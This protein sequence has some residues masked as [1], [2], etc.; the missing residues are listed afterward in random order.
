MSER[1]MVH[2][3]FQKER[4]V[5]TIDAI[6]VFPTKLGIAH[7]FELF[8][9]QG[10]LLV[11]EDNQNV[12]TALREDLAR[13]IP[14]MVPVGHHYSRTSV[15]FKTIR[16]RQAT[17]LDNFMESKVRILPR[18][19]ELGGVF[20]DTSVNGMPPAFIKRYGVWKEL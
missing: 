10:S 9:S 18:D 13:L 5:S 19:Y 8:D 12:I 20:A 7:P 16:Y 2:L 1:Y 4:I 14:R 15:H 3:L 6:V 17:S 11:H